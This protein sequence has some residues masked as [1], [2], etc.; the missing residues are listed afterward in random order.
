MFMEI[1]IAD[2]KN[3]KQEV[4]A[5]ENF[6]LNYKT[7][8]ERYIAD[9]AA[10]EDTL[11]TYFSHI[12][13]FLNW[14]VT[15]AFQPLN[16]DKNILIEYRN[17]L[18]SLKLEIPTI[19]LKLSALRRFYDIAVS[20][21]L[22]AENPVLGVRAPKQRKAANVEGAK[23]IN[24]EQLEYLF[25][26]IPNNG[27]TAKQEE[28]FLRAKCLISLMGLQG[29]RTVETY[30]LSC[31]DIDF[32]KGLMLIKGKGR[33]RYIAPREDVLALLKKYISLRALATPGKDSLGIPVFTSISNNN[34]G[35]RM[36]RCAIRDVVDYWFISAG[37]REKGDKS[38]KSCHL[39]RHTT[40]ALLYQATHDLM[41]VQKEL[42]HVDP[43][44]TSKYAHIQD[45]LSKR[46]TQNIPIKTI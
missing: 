2:A 20:R 30:R 42:G 33:D 11:I 26:I 25:K 29:L 27:D 43:K 10:R 18:V 32:T 21:K 39:L 35:K 40:G 9:G 13:Q 34:T 16:I 12:Q 19:A 24:L 3:L 28:E 46:Y 41:V 7:Y 17:Y 15:E 37:I 4:L 14:C 44:T 23:Y 38:G 5:R 8:L 45:I 31:E 36:S 22:I 1:I 6:L